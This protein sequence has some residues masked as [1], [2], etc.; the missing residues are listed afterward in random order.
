MYPIICTLHI[1]HCK[2]VME[3]IQL[4]RDV[5]ISG[6]HDDVIK[7]KHFLHYWPFV[8]GIHRFPVNSPHKG[9]WRGAL[10]FS[11]I[12]VLINS[13]VNNREAR[14]LRRNPAHSDVTVM[15]HTL[16]LLVH[17]CVTGPQW[18]NSSA[19]SANSP[20]TGLDFSMYIKRY[21]IV[22]F[23]KNYGKA[24]LVNCI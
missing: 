17:T 15:N 7:W 19:I 16:D 1:V 20:V 8:R 14:D 13:W 12:C 22:E 3:K 5:R 23:M 4:S 2:I 10:M 11:L 21:R 18:V 24:S 6:T 9:Q